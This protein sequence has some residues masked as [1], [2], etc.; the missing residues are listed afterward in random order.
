MKFEISWENE[1]LILEL[2]YNKEPIGE[3]ADLCLGIEMK[4]L[5]EFGIGF[6]NSK[7]S[8]TPAV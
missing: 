2:S 5:L 8:K 3:I 1:K 7:I 6:L 4:K